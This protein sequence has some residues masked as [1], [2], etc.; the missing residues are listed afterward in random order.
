MRRVLI[1]LVSGL[2][3]C[4]SACHQEPDKKCPPAVR[5]ATLKGPSAISMVQM[6]SEMDSL[7]HRAV[8]FV[9]VDEP[10][11]VRKMMMQK[12]VDFAVLPS[13]M[14]ALLYNKGVDYQLAGIPVWGT[15]YLF[16]TDTSIS[17]WQDLRGKHIYLMARG[18]T[19][20]IAFRYLLQCHGID[21]MNAVTLDY[22]FPTH[23]D[24]ANAVMGNQASLAVLSEPLVSLVAERNPKV[25]ALFDLN[26][27]WNK[28]HQDT[29][30]MAQ[31]ALLVNASFA[32]EQQ[33]WVAA[34]LKAYDLSVKWVYQNP[35]KAADYIVENKILPTKELALL[36][37]PGCNMQWQSTDSIKSR[38]EAYFQLFYKENPDIL[39]GK[40]PDDDF[41]YTTEAL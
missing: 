32:R 31:T 18:M 25:H 23:I 21:A 40:M 24:L 33:S 7:E 1:I 11:K 36:T 4:L 20:D 28:M 26:A 9:V 13:T 37:L 35:Q 2:L 3:L 8:E 41:Y 27:E 15:L 34:F 29:L 6:L 30:P 17:T 12:E 14:G 19:P 39:G 5:I 38:V 10:L 16:G 22:R